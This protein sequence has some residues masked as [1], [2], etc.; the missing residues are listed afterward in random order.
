MLNIK[1]IFISSEMVD[2]NMPET[3]EMIPP[4]RMKTNLALLAVTIFLISAFRT[5]AQTLEWGSEVFSDLVDS[6]GNTLDT[7]FVFEL[8]AFADGFVPD[9]TNTSSWLKNWRVFDRASY[10]QDNGYFS[11]TVQM[12]DNGRSDS[13]YQTPGTMSFEGLGAYI[14]VRKGDNPVEGSEWL[15]TR[16]NTWTFPTATPGCCDNQPPTQ[17]SVSDLGNGNV[18][19]WGGQGG[20]DG[21]GVHTDFGT[22]TLQTFTFVPEPSS[23][24]LVGMAGAFTVLRRRRTGN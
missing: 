20:I 13:T 21:S 5:E 14:W 11:S 2:K 18:P 1:K 24:L 22:H 6:H 15:L 10:S 4:Y 9:Q 16:A 3:L 23:V 8:G 17:W 19:L 12:L 7:A